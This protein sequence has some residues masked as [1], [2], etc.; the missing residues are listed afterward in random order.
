M[1]IIGVVPPGIGSGITV[2][3]ELLVMTEEG[4]DVIV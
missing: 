2:D 4:L 1:I 3:L